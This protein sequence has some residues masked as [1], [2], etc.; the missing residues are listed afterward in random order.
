MGELFGRD[1]SVVLRHIHNTY[2]SKE[3]Q[4]ATTGAKIAQVASDSKV[5]RIGSVSST[6]FCVAV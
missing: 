3:L 2:K 5:R 6:L 4:N 1:R